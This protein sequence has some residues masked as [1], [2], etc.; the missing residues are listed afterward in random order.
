[1]RII[2]GEAKGRRL[3]FPGKCGARPTSDRIKESLFNILTPLTDKAVLDVFAGAGNV[4]IEALS[5]GAK[6]VVFIE[7]EANLAEYIRKNILLCGFA[8]KHELLGM[9]MEKAIPFLQRRGD[10]FDVIFADPP[11][12]VGLLEETWKKLKSGILL[13]KEGILVV[14]HSVREEP[15]WRQDSELLLFE[16]RKYGDTR[17]SFLKHH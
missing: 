12:E 9:M 14:Q 3:L 17:L 5:R 8:D 11:Y 6:H 4:G 13:T 16:Q 2:G 10:R 1:M 15:Q 7:K